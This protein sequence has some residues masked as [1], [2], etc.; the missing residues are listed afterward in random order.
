MNKAT[1]ATIS[2]LTIHKQKQEKILVAGRNFGCGSSR[3][4]APWAIHDFGIRAVISSEIADI[5]RNNSLKNGL[6]PVIVDA[7]T[8]QWLLRNPG[9]EITVDVKNTCIELPDGKKVEFP[10]EAFARHCILN[11]IDQTGFLMQNPRKYRTFRSGK[12][13]ATMKTTIAVL[14]GDG[15]GTE[16]TREATKVLA[17]IG[18]LFGHEFNINH[19]LIGGAALDEANDPF[20]KETAAICSSADAV[21]LGAVGGPKWDN[22]ATEQRPERGLLR[23][24]AALNVFANLRPVAAHP[25]LKDASPIRAELL[26]GVDMM[27]V[28]ELTGGIYFGEKQRSENSATDVCT[29]TRDEIERVLRIAGNLARQRRG[30]ITSVDKSNVLE[31]SRLWREV[32]NDLLPNEFPELE[33]EHLLVDAAAMHLLSRPADFDVIVTE[34]MFGDI[35]TDE[36]SMLVGSMGM[37]PSASLNDG[38]VGLYEPIH[39][40]APDIAGQNKANP[41]ATIMSLAMLLRHSLGLHKEAESVEAA[42]TAALRQ[43]YRTGDIAN[44]E[45]PSTVNIVGTAEMGDAITAAVTI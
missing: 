22:V 8:H 15:I 21:L 29:Y 42:V 26:Q 32:T 35:L 36:A 33:V 23:L 25:V 34:N 41:C 45:D 38:K 31:T 6:V 44:I 18:E 1:Y 19:G 11:G 13:L 7:T 39:G 14:P 30:K 28:R 12:I 20:P 27:V 5:F 3:E 10:I 43:G 37:L 2:H 9:A 17:R 16:V 4:H 24:R 40:S